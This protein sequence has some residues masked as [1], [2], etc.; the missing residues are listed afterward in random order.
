[1][2]KLK[3]GKKFSFGQHLLELRALI[4][5]RRSPSK[6]LLDTLRDF[7]TH[8]DRA[9]GASPVCLPATAVEVCAPIINHLCEKDTDDSRK[10]LR[11]AHY[12]LRR[13]L[14]SPHGRGVPKDT[15]ESIVA[16]LERREMT[17]KHQPRRM[18]A[19]RTLA[20]CLRCI[21]EPEA[22]LNQLLLLVRSGLK[23][24]LTWN[25]RVSSAKRRKE[26]LALHQELWLA[27]A[28]FSTSAYIV[29][30]VFEQFSRGASSTDLL[31]YFT[32]GVCM[33]EWQSPSLR[34]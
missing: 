20:C 9:A 30:H 24:C 8:D 17:H 18:E 22:L 2:S 13:V 25:Q 3:T 12:L 28:Y 5:S 1:M 11:V 23:N 31:E 4:A 34:R 21:R 16:T 33:G 26:Q 19:L 6:K 7:C 27:Q 10:T 14:S 29:N 32:F 15:L